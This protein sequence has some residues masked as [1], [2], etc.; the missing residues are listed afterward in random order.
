MPTPPQLVSKLSIPVMANNFIPMQ[1]VSLAVGT[2]NASSVTFTNIPSSQRVTY[3][4]SNVGTKA[5]FLSGTNSAAPVAAIVATSTP[6]PT[7]TLISISTCDCLPA[8]AILTQDYP[9]GTDTISAIC[10][11]TDTT[12]LQISIGGGQ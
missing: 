4:F 3:K 2:A 12:T 1:S 11:G 5:A 10:G 8:G 9:G 7:S 6:Q